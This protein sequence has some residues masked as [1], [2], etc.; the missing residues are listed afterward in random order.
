MSSPT[1]WRHGAS[2]WAAFSAPVVTAISTLALTRHVIALGMGYGVR[3]RSVT[4]LLSKLR[5]MVQA[6]RLRR[7]LCRQYGINAP[8]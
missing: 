5:Y 3:P 8:A 1:R 6:A 2:G 4:V 7:Q